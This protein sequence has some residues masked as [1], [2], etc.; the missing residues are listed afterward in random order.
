VKL[1]EKGYKITPKQE[2]HAVTNVITSV[3]S[4]QSASRLLKLKKLSFKEV[5]IQ[6]HNHFLSFLALSWIK[7]LG[8]IQ[9]R[10]E[11]VFACFILF[12]QNIAFPP[13]LI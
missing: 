6:R 1:K 12:I 9:Y 13:Q 3:F 5:K 2:T 4:F 7:Q 11:I 10:F 8:L